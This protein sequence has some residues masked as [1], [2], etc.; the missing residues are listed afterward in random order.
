MSIF[1][2]IKTERGMVA[3]IYSDFEAFPESVAAHFE[4]NK[5]LMLVENAPLPRIEREYLAQET[6]RSN[7][8]EYCGT[9]HKQAYDNLKLK[10][11]IPDERLEVL[12][13]LADLLTHRPEEAAKFKPEFMS[14]GFTE[15]EWQHAVN[16]IAYFNYTNRLAFAM[17]MELEVGY[18]KSCN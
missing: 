17:G 7:G 11:K 5:A 2:K 1:S 3:R 4:M 12:G 15:A 9:H 10:N 13:E 6:S 8:N 16:I 18:E 14:V